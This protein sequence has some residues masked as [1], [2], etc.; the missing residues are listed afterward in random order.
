M[1]RVT[2]AM[3]RTVRHHFSR[4]VATYTEKPRD[5]WVFDYEGQPALCGTQIWWSIEVK[6]AFLR[7]EEGFENAMKDY[8]KKQIAQLNALINLLVGD[9]S[10]GDRQK[11]M[12]I[13]TIDV[14]ARDVVA[15]LIHMKAESA[16][17]FQWQSQLKHGYTLLIYFLYNFLTIFS[18]FTFYYN[19]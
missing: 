19:L 9:L 14:H 16:S 6:E 17:D 8:Q 12:T 1:N 4:A 10:P 18:N 13:C 15:T 3:R 7:L 2:E 11:I 5:K